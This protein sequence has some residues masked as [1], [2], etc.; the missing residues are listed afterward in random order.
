MSGR[1]DDQGVDALT[2]LLTQQSA[3][4]IHAPLMLTRPAIPGRRC[5]AAGFLSV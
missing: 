3:E 4:G 1:F 2:A 5:S